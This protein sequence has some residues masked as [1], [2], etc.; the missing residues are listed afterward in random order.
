MNELPQDRAKVLFI[1]TH[2]LGDLLQ[3]FPAFAMVRR[4]LPQ[5]EIHLLC[6]DS[7][8]ALAR[9]CPDLDRVH[10]FV[11][12]QLLPGSATG[13]FHQAEAVLE[14]GHSLKNERYTHI[15]NLMGNLSAALLGS[16][17][18]GE[19]ARRAGRSFSAE[20]LD[21]LEQRWARILMALPAARAWQPFHLSEIFSR[22]TAEAIGIEAELAVPSVTV[23][24]L[25]GLEQARQLAPHGDE[26]GW[27]ALRRPWVGLQG[28]ASKGLR[29][30][31]AAWLRTFG[32]EFLGQLG[33]SLFLMG[34]AAEAEA[35]DPLLRSLT[36]SQRRRCVQ[37]CGMLDLPSMASLVAN[38]DAVASVDTFTLHL[39]A[40]VDTPVLGLF[41]G[42]AS[43]HE[44]GPWGSGHLVLWADRDGGPCDCEQACASG[45]E[46]WERL[47]PELAVGALGLLLMKGETGALKGRR[48]RAFETALDRRQYHL[49]SADGQR[50]REPEWEAL[51]SLARSWAVGA[52]RP[53]AALSSEIGE[54][55]RRFGETL[56][57]G[58]TTDFGLRKG[59][60]DWF[61]VQ[62]LQARGESKA[63]SRKG[64]EDVAAGCGY[65]AEAHGRG[66]RVTAS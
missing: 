22:L 36:Q 47:H 11:R 17:A 10:S 33:G 9:L 8:V 18:A 43:P 5:A 63:W 57:G 7:C 50:E 40:A 42:P 41:P 31:P 2:R 26:S 28:G 59:P 24:R 49:R 38:L 35:F 20:G 39:A 21:P 27:L 64:L 60:A 3:A 25:H 44:T 1:L 30:P 53:E 29:R 56:K 6:D 12:N 58:T 65:F 32:R 34:T 48:V 62:A 46:C 23:N 55:F 37:A 15:V 61:R 51:A 66:Q 13:A 52:P 19:G 16:I 45:T 54:E 4:R 14:L